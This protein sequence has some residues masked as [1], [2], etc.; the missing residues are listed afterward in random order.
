MNRFENKTAVITVSYTHLDVYKRQTKYNIT[1]IHFFKRINQ[2]RY[3]FS[4]EFYVYKS[5]SSFR[6]VYKRQR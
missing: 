6:D 2:I 5:C 4:N 1:V 3:T